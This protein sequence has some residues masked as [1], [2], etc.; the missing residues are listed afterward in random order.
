MAPNKVTAKTSGGEEPGPK[1]VRPKKALPEEAV[2]NGPTA[3]AKAESGPK[4]GKKV[5]RD[6]DAPFNAETAQV[7][8]DVD[9][10]KNL[11]HYPSLEAMFE[12]LGI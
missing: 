3:V 1:K 8:R 2:S 12:D 5:R 7:L 11:V 4:S 6:K 10:G 9:A